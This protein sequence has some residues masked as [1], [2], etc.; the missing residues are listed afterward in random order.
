MELRTSKREREG[1]WGA[2]ESSYGGDVGG[3]DDG[4]LFR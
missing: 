1:G 3:L 2:R 4:E